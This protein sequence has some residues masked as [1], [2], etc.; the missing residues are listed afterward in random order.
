MKINKGC[1]WR[2][3]IV[4]SLVLSLVAVAGGCGSSNSSTP[5]GSE[6]AQAS[7]QAEKKYVIKYGFVASPQ[8]PHLAGG[9]DF[10]KRVEE[11]SGGRIEV[12]LY[13]SSQLGDK[14]QM[15]EG[16][17]AGTIEMTEVAA[18]D[19]SGFSRKWSVFS[20]PYLFNDRDHMFRVLRDKEVK[21]IL[22]KDAEQC[23]VKVLMYWGMGTRS[24]I[25][26]KRP[27]YRPE[28]LNG[29]KIRVMQ[30]PILAETVNAMGANGVPLAWSE[31]YTALQQKT[32]DGLEQSAPLYVDAKLYEVAKY[33]SLT[34][35]F[36]IP[37]AHLI[38]LK[39]WNSLPKDL[40]DVLLKAAQQTEEEFFKI[41]DKYEEDSLKTLKDSGVQINQV[42]KAAFRDRVKP[43]YD[44][45]A[46]QIGPDLIQKMQKVQ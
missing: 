26:A 38:S 25:N 22:S 27:V 46:S 33:F 39:F 5:K 17:R 45:Y 20:L 2:F 6:G 40:Q 36:L 19:L 23:G 1:F 18:T 41:W 3:T 37:D 35:H 21:E 9:A 31:V 12:Q 28:D 10:K 30:D 42:D 14:L 34:E 44:K 24:I 11:L 13:P 4:A 16:V 29:L 15:V 43:I 8:S 32:I 7:K